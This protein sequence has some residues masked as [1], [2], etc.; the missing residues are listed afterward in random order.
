MASAGPRI[1]ANSAASG[2]RGLARAAGERDDRA[3]RSG[4]SAAT[5]R[6]TFSVTVPGTAPVRSSGTASWPHWKPAGSHGA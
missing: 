3:S 1:E 4:C 6:L 2:M 5:T